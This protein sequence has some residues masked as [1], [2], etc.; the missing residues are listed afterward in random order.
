MAAKKM[1]AKKTGAKKSSD[2]VAPTKAAAKAGSDARSRAKKYGTPT[3]KTTV[4]ERNVKANK[5][6]AAVAS[7]VTSKTTVQSSRGNLY[8][9]Y[10]S[11]T[12][13]FMAKDSKPTTV[14]SPV[15][16]KSTTNQRAKNQ[17]KK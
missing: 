3:G 9:V 14:V 5:R 7:D 6:N 1:A 11:K 15:A 13:R 16:K 4:S 12:Q 2:V 17:K 8:N 10:E